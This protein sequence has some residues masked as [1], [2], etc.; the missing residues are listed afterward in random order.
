MF[1]HRRR[2][3][4]PPLTSIPLYMVGYSGLLSH[5]II[6]GDVGDRAS[7]QVGV[8]GLPERDILSLGVMGRGG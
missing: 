2:R 4:R 6:A 7:Q 1:L 5:T 8:R 3:C